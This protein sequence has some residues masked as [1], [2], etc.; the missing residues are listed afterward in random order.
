MISEP[1][2]PATPSYAPDHPQDYRPAETTQQ[3]D[4]C[5]ECNQPMRG[6]Q[7]L[8]IQT[9]LDPHAVRHAHCPAPQPSPTAEELADWNEHESHLAQRT[10]HDITAEKHSQTAAELRR[11][12]AFERAHLTNVVDAD[13]FRAAMKPRTAEECRA[14]AQAHLAKMLPGGLPAP[15]ADATAGGDASLDDLKDFELVVTCDGCGK[16]AKHAA[17][18]RIIERH[19]QAATNELREE[20]E[21]LQKLSG[22]QGALAQIANLGIEEETARAEQAEDLIKT[23]ELAVKSA[24]AD[25]AAMTK[26]HMALQT[27][28]IESACACTDALD[29]LT[30]ST[31]LVE[32]LR[33]AIGDAEWNFQH[34]ESI[35]GHHRIHTARALLKDA[36]ALVEKHEKNL[37][38]LTTNPNGGDK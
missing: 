3:A 9:G 14:T 32:K 26:D 30:A 12:A 23:M 5:P 31:A 8:I 22:T 16:D 35:L 11:L 24:E 21:R 10:G 33:Q 27:K 34:V 25:L 29:K 4:I 1:T 20:N 7:L 36:L 13:A 38:A 37:A 19:R 2:P 17:V 6:D 15:A 28:A 18:L